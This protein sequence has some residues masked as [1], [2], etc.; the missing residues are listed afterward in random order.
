MINKSIPSKTKAA[1]P[2]P[3]PFKINNSNPLMKKITALVLLSFLAAA[4]VRADVVWQEL[5]NYTNGPISVTSTNGTGSTTISNWVTHSGNIDAYVNNNQLEV[6]STTAYRG[7]TVTRSGDVHRNFSLTNNCPY[8]NGQ[9]VVYASFVVTFTNLPMTNTA[10]SYFAHFLYS[11]TGFEGKL[12]GTQGNPGATAPANFRGLPNTYRLGVA[13]AGTSGTY[14]NKVY[15]VDLALNTPYQVVMCWDPVADY[16]VSL[17]INPISS[18]DP[19]VESNDTFTPTLA[20]IANGFA[21]RQAS[22]FGGFVDVSNVVIATTFAEAATNVWTT[23]AVAPQIVYQPTAV[24]SNFVGATFTLSAVANGQGLGN[25]TYKWQVSTSPANTSPSDVTSGDLSGT[26]AN[27]LSFDY[28]DTPD[29]GYYTLVATT[30]YGLSVTSSVAKVAITATP[31]PPAFVTQPASQTVYKGQ[32]VTFSTS[33]SSPGNITYTWYS[34]NVVVSSSYNPA[35]GQAD[36]GSSSSYTLNNVRTSFSGAQFKVAVTN[37]VIANGVVS[38]NAVLTVVNPQ[39]VTI[40]YL[41]TLVDPGTGFYPTNSPPTI[42]YQ[43][44]GT[45]TTFTNITSGNTAS[46]YLQDGTAGINI[47]ATGGSSFRPAQGDVVTFVGVLSAYTTGLELY[48]D[49]ADNN[50]PY[51]S[52]TDTGVTNALPAPISIPFTVTNASNITNLNLNIAESLVTLSDVYFGTNAGAAIT[53]HIITVTNSSGQ[54]FNLQT[55]VLDQDTLNQTFPAYAYSV[56]GVLYG[57][58]TNFSIAI[59]RFA[60]IVTTPPPPP[61]TIIPTVSPCIS[62][63]VIIGGN[64]VICGTN[65]QATG[66]YYL[67]AST[68]VAKPLSQWMVVATNVVCTNGACGAFTFTGTNAAVPGGQ[69]QFYILSNTNSNHP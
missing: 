11:G 27:V 15:P 1:V 20:N 14:V 64:A 37:D 61:P 31:V 49:T 30:S 38:T 17:W 5:F 18:S 48:A 60:D 25:M 6:S 44:T 3:S 51:T 10:G 19:K 62:G 26:T 57:I 40:A 41:R 68:N 54:R 39:Q 50:Y 13:A 47:F 28:A 58:N 4:S 24:I 35:P 55:F 29:S 34:N 63:V 45:V 22:S 52:Y 12:W 7:V 8:T 69:Q 9:Q 53:N 66:V 59:T 36:N 21:F 16:A 67:L 65:A 23:N 2:P 33:V 56:T 42:P 43:I 46:Y 32:T